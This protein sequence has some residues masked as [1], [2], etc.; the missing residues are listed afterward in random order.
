VPR[1]VHAVL[2]VLTDI[3]TAAARSSLISSRWL[4]DEVAVMRVAKEAALPT[5]EP[6]P[7]HRR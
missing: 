7:C 5:I 4:A 6:M 1:A 3:A 2:A